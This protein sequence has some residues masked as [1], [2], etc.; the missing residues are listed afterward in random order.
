MG[1]IRRSSWG[2]ANMHVPGGRGCKTCKLRSRGASERGEQQHRP[3]PFFPLDT[4]V[5]RVL[6]EPPLGRRRATVVVTW[7][8]GKNGE[9]MKGNARLTT[10]LLAFALMWSALLLVQPPAASAVP[11][12]LTDDAYTIGGSST[13]TGGQGV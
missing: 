10:S 11:G 5:V 9:Q 1:S 3:Q 8:A 4:K 2:I 13:N 12:K 7:L 6:S